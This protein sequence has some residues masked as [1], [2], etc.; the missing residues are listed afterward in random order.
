[1]NFL[2]NV[3]I[4]TKLILFFAII[5]VLVSLIGITNITLI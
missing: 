5:V 1:M 3:K 2:K 4:K